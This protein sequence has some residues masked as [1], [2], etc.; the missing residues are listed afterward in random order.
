MRFLKT[1]DV[2]VCTDYWRVSLLCAISKV[3]ENVTYN[4]LFDFLDTVAIL[5]NS[6]FGFRKMHSTNMAL[7]TSLENDQYL[8]DICL[9]FERPSTLLAIWYNWKCFH[10]V[11]F[12]GIRGTVQWN[13]FVKTENEVWYL[14]RIYSRLFQFIHINHPGFVCWRD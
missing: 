14:T 12:N 10:T 6:Q 8:L 3:F 4:I 13:L 7:T 11:R 9:N 1:L 2:F 5:S